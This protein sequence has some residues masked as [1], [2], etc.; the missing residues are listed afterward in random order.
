MSKLVTLKLMEQDIQGLVAHISFHCCISHISFDAFN[1]P[2]CTIGHTFVVVQ[3]IIEYSFCC[4]DSMV[5]SIS[6]IFMYILF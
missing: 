3:H 1:I 2:I 6:L 4:F 5:L